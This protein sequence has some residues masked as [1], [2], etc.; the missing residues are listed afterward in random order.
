MGLIQGYKE[1]TCLI[2]KEYPINAFNLSSQQD[3]IGCHWHEN[4]EI[5]CILEGQARF[6]IGNEIIE[7]TSQDF[8]M[9][10]PNQSH[11]GYSI[12]NMQVKAFAL[13]F[14]SSL[15]LDH[16]NLELMKMI[17]PYFSNEYTIPIKVCKDHERSIHFKIL[18]NVQEE[19]MKKE[20]GYLINV[21][22]LMTIFF[23]H[24][25]RYNVPV[26]NK[27]KEATLEKLKKERL[28]NL[29]IYIENNYHH[30]ITVD[31]ASKIVGVTPHYF[32]KLFKKITG[33]TF[34]QYLNL[35]RINKAEEVIEKTDRPITEIAFDFGF[36]N[37]NYFDQVF[38]QYKGY[39]PSS[40]RKG[41]KE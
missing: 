36:C 24:L 7:V 9:V 15:L 6:H 3:I 4:F 37:I 39:M 34:I 38:K 1:D 16:N 8:M 13:V 20:K 35:Y 22:S 40:I 41:L 5:I 19:L 26:L 32:C 30:K 14:H 33:R 25:T 17:R 27:G 18:Q 23:V 2:S 28:E 11:Y 31:D 29:F 10:R 12:N 21:K